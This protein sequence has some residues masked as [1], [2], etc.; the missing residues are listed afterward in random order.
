MKKLL[1]VLFISLIG[2]CKG[3]NCKSFTKDGWRI[4]YNKFYKKYVVMTTS[5]TLGNEYLLKDHNGQYG[6]YG[7]GWWECENLYSC[8]SKSKSLFINPCDAKAFLLTYI[9]K[10][11]EDV[12]E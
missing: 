11:K 1:T 9:R 7:D 2:I 10:N 5:E 4:G 12:W 6:I 8:A 3:Q